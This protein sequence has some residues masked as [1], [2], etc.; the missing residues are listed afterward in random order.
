MLSKSQ[1][2]FF[3]IFIAMVI[4]GG[5]F[6]LPVAYHLLRTGQTDIATV[7]LFLILGTGCFS[8]F[9]KVMSIAGHCEMIFAAGERIGSILKEKELPEPAVPV[10][11]QKHDIELKDVSFQYGTGTQTVLKNVSAK[12]PESSFTAI[13]GPSGSGKTTLVHLIARMW[14]LESGSISIGGINIKSIGTAGLN[15]AVGTVFQ[16]VQML[17]ATVRS[18]ICMNKTAVSQKEIENAARTACCHDFIMSLPKGY[19]T[20]I[21]EGG[22]VHLSGGEKQRIA[23]ARAVLKNPPVILLDEAS[24]YTDAENETNI[25]KAFSRVMRNKTVVVIAHR[26][27][28]IVRADNILVINNGEI[29]EQGRHNELLSKNGLYKKMWEAHSKAKGWKL[30]EMEVV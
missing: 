21:G 26:L 17:T 28:T 12:L 19:D 11:P 27:S 30:S 9:V 1:T 2:P 8:E 25:Q 3:V 4:G 15:Q 23:I 10:L 24:C 18:N 22:E 5:I 13:V 16:D 20:V 14:D 6:I 7:L 29:T